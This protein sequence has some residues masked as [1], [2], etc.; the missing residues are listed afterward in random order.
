M[1]FSDK[2]EEKKMEKKFCIPKIKPATTQT[3]RKFNLQ[4]QKS[5]GTKENSINNTEIL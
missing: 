1:L 3:K 2:P 4:N 5:K